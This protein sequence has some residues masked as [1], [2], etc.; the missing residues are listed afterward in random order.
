MIFQ[1]PKSQRWHWNFLYFS[2]TSP[3]H[4][5]QRAAS[6]PKSTS[7]V[8]FSCAFAWATM[9]FVIATISR[10][11]AARASRPCSICASFCSH[12]AVSSGE[13]SSFTSRPW[14]SVI[15]WNAFA[16]GT[17]SLPSRRMYFSAIS[18]SMV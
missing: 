15:S 18:P 4:L 16:V 5:G 12:S 9:C 17:S 2:W 1:K 7:I 6:V 3:P 10:M 11:N 13:K 8:S 14:R